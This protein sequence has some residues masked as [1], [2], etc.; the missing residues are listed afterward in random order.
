MG[1][2]WLKNNRNPTRANQITAVDRINRNKVEAAVGRF[3]ESKNILIQAKFSRINE[4]NNF[5]SLK[6]LL[7][8]IYP[9]LRSKSCDYLY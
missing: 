4:N 7:V 2:D 1:S 5:L 3:G 6:N 9:K 8:R